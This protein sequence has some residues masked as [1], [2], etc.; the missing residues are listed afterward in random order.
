MH[1][2]NIKT[3]DFLN[4]VLQPQKSF[5]CLFGPKTV[6]QILHHCVGRCIYFFFKCLKDPL[7]VVCGVLKKF[8]DY[9]SKIYQF[10]LF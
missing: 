10:H 8:I 7:Q 2:G 6:T 3:Q 4:K 1:T 5:D 9:D